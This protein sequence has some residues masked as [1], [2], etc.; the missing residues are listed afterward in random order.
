MFS[1]LVVTPTQ[2][3]RY[4]LL[5]LRPFELLARQTN[6]FIIRAAALKQHSFILSNT[7]ETVGL[8]Q[9]RTSQCWFVPFEM[10]SHSVYLSVSVL[11][12]FYPV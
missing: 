9:H 3:N 8:W 2:E 11:K 12:D 1:L 4:E 5:L 7:E 6:A 10:K